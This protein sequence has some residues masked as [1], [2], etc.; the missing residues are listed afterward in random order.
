MRLRRA[1]VESRP[2][3]F[4]PNLARSLAVVGHCRAAAAQSDGALAALAEAILHL[5][6]PFAALP[7]AH[8][9]LMNMPAL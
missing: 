1:L 6:P 7:T 3:A 8:A 5:T 4:M 9:G 2:D